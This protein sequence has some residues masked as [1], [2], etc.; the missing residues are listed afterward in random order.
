MEQRNGSSRLNY[1]I[2]L[3][4][5]IL[6]LFVWVGESFVDIVFYRDIRMAKNL[7]H[8][9]WA[10]FWLHLALST[11]I[12]A[13]SIYVT[14]LIS[15]IKFSKTR[16][17]TIKNEWEDTFDGITEPI[18]IHD[19]A[20]K[21]TRCNIAYR[22]AVAMPFEKIIGKPYYEVFPIMPGPFKSC[23]ANAGAAKKETEEE[24]IVPETGRI[25]RVKPYPV[26]T[27]SGIDNH[28]VHIMEEI[29][30][31]RNAEDKISRQLK[32][33]EAINRISRT[34]NSSFDI[35][36]TLE[37]IVNEIL[38][39]MHADAVGVMLY[40][41]VT[42]RLE[43][44]AGRGF[45]SGGI[46]KTSL[47]IGEGLA[48]RAVLECKNVCCVDPSS[49]ETGFQRAPLIEKEGFHSYCC[50]PL[51]S[52]GVIKG[53][54]D[55]FCK[56]K[57]ITKKDH[58]ELAETIAMQASIAIDNAEMFTSLR[59]SNLELTLA[60]DTTLEGWSRA[61]DLRDKETEGHS[62]RVT[63]MTV[64]L[65]KELGVND[66][67]LIHVR[68]GALLHD[69]GKMGVPDAI[70]LKPG[71][72][73]AEEWTLMKKHPVYARDM[74]APIEY[75]HPAIDI[76]YCH[77]EKWDGTGYPREL[78]QNDIPLAARIFSIVDVYDAL[79]SDR[80]YRKAWPE[81]KVMDHILSLSGKDF[82][83]EIVSVFIKN[84]RAAIPAKAS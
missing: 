56:A 50:I 17:E 54:I 5:I 25:F 52:K 8:G 26:A 38:E 51:V 18:F 28:S 67:E 49:A 29:T 60:Y 12:I 44:K 32:Y 53:A 59:R 14:L 73:G 37:F 62:Q 9:A 81:E 31:K 2:I 41:P 4:G 23:A 30:G 22:D 82:D 24:F 71:P 6:A 21:I 63:D 78:K 58:S 11:L 1:K 76:P 42:Q 33:M 84:R 13:F 75:L 39:T 64:H 34:I 74:L 68:R 47:R 66:A 7:L 3:A 57:T 16:I 61:L 83:P 80:P 70:L 20:F 36:T 79:R 27:P 10:H 55:I 15:Q 69:I 43:Y 35:S 72:L 19:A 65:A 77:H 45:L 40:D 46:E 48:G